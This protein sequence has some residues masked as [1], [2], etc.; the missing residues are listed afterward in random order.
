MK[1]ILF[2][3]TGM[4]GNR[5]LKEALQ[6]GH[7][8]T[9]VVRDPSRFRVEDFRVNAVKGD[10]LDPTSV[11][12]AVRGHDAVLSAIGPGADVIVGAARSLLE[13][14]QRAGVKRLVIVG[15]AGSLDVAPGKL[16]VDALDF[17]AEYLDQAQA[18][19]EALNIYRQNETIDWTFVSPATWI[20]PGERTGK[21]RLGNDQLLCDAKGE[22]HI[23][24]EDYA[25]AFLDEVESPRHIRCRFTV[26][27]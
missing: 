10:V 23:S 22:S 17:P 6:R 15:G 12:E 13:G 8:V 20:T 21:F 16:F 26:A 3:A 14:L 2:G 27:Y 5:I 25:I 4:I 1:L 19:C 18:G 9:A 7:Q 24:A 11:A